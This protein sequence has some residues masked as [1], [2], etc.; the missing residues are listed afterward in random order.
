M[1]ASMDR[2]APLPA[3][4]RCAVYPAAAFAVETG[5]LSGD[6]IGGLA[7]VVAGDAYVLAR[8]SVARE[9]VLARGPGG[10]VVGA[11]SSVGIAGQPVAALARHQ[12]MSERGA[13]VELLVLDVDGARLALPLGTLSPADE[14]TLLS[15]EP[16]AGELAGAAQVSFTRGT[17]ITMADGR[18]RPVE[19]LVVGDR[20]LTRDH[21]PQP[22]RWT[23]RQTVRAE[24]SDAPV[25]IGE[26]VLNAA[27]ELVLS[28]DHRLFVH[29]RRD[30]LGAGRA[31]A[32]VRARHLVDG[33]T[34][35]RA[36]GG[37]VD[38]FHVLFDA[39]EIIYVECIPAES[40]LVSPDV[41]AGLDADLAAD[42]RRRMAGT[43]QAPH[44]GVEPPMA[45]LDGL[46]PAEL[47]RRMARR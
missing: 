7:E 5:A 3:L 38:Y 31:E 34:V 18:Q 40:L 30:L 41:M 15:S 8:G 25:V 26:G 47:L 24:G 33:D 10:T 20:V 44:H 1:V 39:H 29:Q 27:R 2:I 17:R 37:H 43:V 46:G 19:G 35:W 28:P 32:L 42:L 6:A 23:G 21:G 16:A 14:Y 11:G 36:P 22:V 9:L 4:G 12:L 13:V 45:G